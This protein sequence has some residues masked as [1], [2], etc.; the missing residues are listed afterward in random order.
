LFGTEGVDLIN[1][2]GSADVVF[3][4][5]GDDIVNAGAG[6][7]FAFGGSGKDILRGEAGRDILF[8]E[9]GNDTLAGG[10]GNDQLF[11]GAGNDTFVFQQGDGRDLVFDF[12]SGAGS[13]DVVQLDAAAFADFNA[14]MQSGAVSDTQ[15]GTEI[16]YADGS[17]ITLVGVNKAS[18]TVDDFRFA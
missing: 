14:L 4:Q 9:N 11:G 3:G 2:R 6:N 1:A 7:D 5:G 16:G 12:K 10:Q 17:S 8:G 13:E 15:L 18:L